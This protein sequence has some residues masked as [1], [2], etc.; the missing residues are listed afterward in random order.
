MSRLSICVHGHFYQPPRENPWLEA[1]EIQDSAYPYHDWNERIAAE[2]YAPNSASRITDREGRI[3]RIVSNYARISFNFGPTLLSWLET[4]T[5]EIYKAILDADR[6]SIA[7]RSGHGS[8][9]AQVHSHII[10]PLANTRDKRTQVIWGIADFVSRFKRFPEGMWLSEAAVDLETLDILAEQGILFTI[11]SPYQAAKIRKTGAGK[12]EDVSGGLIDPTRA[13]RCVLPTGREIA[14]FFYDGP[15]SQAVAFEKILTNGEAFAGRLLSG[16]SDARNWPQILNISTDGET[17]GHHHRFGDMALTYALNF[18]ETQGT[19]RLTNYG[20][21]LHNNPPTEEVQ[22]FE[23]SSWSCAHG[24]ERWRA[25]CGCNLDGGAGWNQEWREPLRNALDWLR[26]QMAFRYDYRAKEYLK[27]PWKARD[28]YIGVILDRSTE[29]V[30]KFF[31]RHAEHILTEKEQSEA[32]RLLEQQRHAMLMYTSCGWFFD[33]LSGI[34]TIQILQYAGRAIQLTSELFDDGIEEIF[35]ERLSEAKSNIPQMKDAAYIYNSRI[36]P[37]V[38]DLKKVGV[39]YAISSLF[40]AYAD[41]ADVYCYEIYREDYH[42]IDAGRMKLAIGRI[43]VKS[44][45]TWHEERLSFCVLHLGNH[46]LNGGVR[47]YLGDEKYNSM[48]D[49]IISAF[50]LGDLAGVIRQMDHYFEKNNYSLFHLFRDEQRK[51]LNILIS[52]TIE[53]FEE[54]YRGMYEN[55][56]I[57]MSFLKETGM[58]VPGFFITAA[59]YTLNL[60]MKRQFESEET[61]MEQLKQLLAEISKWELPLETVTLEFLIRKKL[62][63]MTK[64]LLGDPSAFEGLQKILLLLNAVKALPIELNLW[65][66]QNIYHRIV[67]SSFYRKCLAGCRDGNEE[68]L[69]WIEIFRKAGEMLGFNTEAILPVKAGAE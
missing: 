39:H 57:L 68:C 37:T 12:W 22:I 16:F 65:E 15:I 35:I 60:D 33:E 50:E 61:N 41:R 10:M 23:D 17:Y 52:E 67:Q 6:Q 43:T 5:P 59:E 55:N 25:N 42:R 64:A 30:G 49:S 19:A 53:R 13:Y 8:A 69:K 48:K 66:T 32:L 46:A 47:P 18:I 2:C 54:A 14:I 1:I 44:R 27:D 21:F 28:D 40:E 45:I 51:I 56:R 31:E 3:T 20:E 63:E 24:V 58:P 36:R 4:C 9:L 38:I 62:E 11:L 7:W 34:E 29:N 26:D